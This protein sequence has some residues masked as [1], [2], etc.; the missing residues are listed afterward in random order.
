MRT[1]FI[2]I[3]LI[4]F[5]TI[6]CNKVKEGKCEN[7]R[8]GIIIV[9]KEPYKDYFGDKLFAEFYPLKEGNIQFE[10]YFLVISKLPY[11]YQETLY[12]FLY[13]MRKKTLILF[14]FVLPALKKL[15]YNFKFYLR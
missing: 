7:S 8:E 6:G 11:I 5:F 13:L 2:L 15:T 3:I 14:K 9:C 10:N 12:R 1:K 4:T